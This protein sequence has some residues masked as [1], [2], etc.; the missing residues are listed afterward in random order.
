MI[1]YFFFFIFFIFYAIEAEV[2]EVVADFRKDDM[3]DESS[4]LSGTLNTDSSEKSSS[5]QAAAALLTYARAFPM[6]KDGP[7][8][9]EGTHW[10][11]NAPSRL[12]FAI[13]SEWC[14]ECLSSLQSFRKY[15]SMR[16]SCEGHMLNS[17]CIEGRF[18]PRRLRLRVHEFW[19]AK[20][21]TLLRMSQH[22]A[23]TSYSLCHDWVLS[24]IANERIWSQLGNFAI[25][26][27]METSIAT[28]QL[29]MAALCLMAAVAVQIMG[30]IWKVV[31]KVPFAT[32]IVVLSAIS[33][34]MA[35]SF[36]SLS[37]TGVRPSNSGLVIMSLLPRIINATLLLCVILLF[38]KWGDAVLSI[39]IS[40]RATQVTLACF[41]C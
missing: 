4:N 11:C 7:C 5:P 31:R 36:W 19:E 28:P 17:S 8:D 38:Y 32:S 1:G 40:E 27:N 20:M 35:I 23:C 30:F 15:D 26:G 18:F 33:S 25:V 12:S 13:S 2:A 16:V 9:E 29:T 3:S 21:N 14:R 6:H 10:P 41:L 22:T 37:L 34:S 39:V 24:S